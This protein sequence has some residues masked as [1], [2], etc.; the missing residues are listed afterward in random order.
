MVNCSPF[1]MSLQAK[2]ANRGMYFMVS[3]R[4]SF[5]VGALRGFEYFLFFWELFGN[6]KV[7]Q[8]GEQEWLKNR[9]KLPLCVGSMEYRLL[10]TAPVMSCK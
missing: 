8:F 5:S 1:L 4:R 2:K 3:T 10:S 6:S 9:P 7:V